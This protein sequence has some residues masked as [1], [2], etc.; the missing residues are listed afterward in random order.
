[1]KPLAGPMPALPDAYIG[2]KAKPGNASAGAGRRAV[3]K[4][5][6]WRKKRRRF[7]APLK[8][9]KGLRAFLAI[10]QPLADVQAF[11]LRS[12]QTRISMT[13]L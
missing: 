1:M 12:V 7:S 11:A 2:D 10:L 3:D 8:R 6:P 5:A 13:N 9:T 4:V